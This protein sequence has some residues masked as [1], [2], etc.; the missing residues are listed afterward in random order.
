MASGMIDKMHAV[1]PNETVTPRPFSHMPTSLHAN[2]IVG[3]L[4]S[5]NLQVP[6]GLTSAAAKGE[7]LRASGHRF[8]VKEVDGV[9]TAANVPISDR[10]RFKAALDRNGI[11]GN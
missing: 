8:P 5:L 6:T 3:V 9:L 1:A 2:A 11:L 7:A 10:F 4:R